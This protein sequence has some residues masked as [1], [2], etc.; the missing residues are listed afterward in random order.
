MV[1]G[2]TGR[3][4]D[5]QVA[6]RRTVRGLGPH[7]RTIT[8]TRLATYSHGGSSSGTITDRRISLSDL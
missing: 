7:P 4:I 8:S 6:C 2:P 3:I 5:G 1:S